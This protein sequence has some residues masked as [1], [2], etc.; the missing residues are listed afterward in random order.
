[1]STQPTDK[2]DQDLE[3]TEPHL[4]G[5]HVLQKELLPCPFCGAHGI[6]ANGPHE[7]ILAKCG[8]AD[9]LC[10]GNQLWV[11]YSIWNQRATP[12]VSDAPESESASRVS[13]P[14]PATEK[15]GTEA[16]EEVIA[17]HAENLHRWLWDWTRGTD[18]SCPELADLSEV[19]RDAV[20]EALSRQPEQE[21]T[22][23]LLTDCRNEIAALTSFCDSGEDLTATDRAR[24]KN[25]FQRIDAARDR[26]EV[27]E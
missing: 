2:P 12:S 8:G 23:R 11:L 21:D 5:A 3:V 4:D 9:R 18:C 16:V 17:T 19:I 25:L 13:S 6:T 15:P 14:S 10:A 20:A 22:A 7:T 24:I 1:M 26:K 27:K